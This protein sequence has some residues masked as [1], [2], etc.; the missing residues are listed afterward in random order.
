[1]ERV[2]SALDPH[3]QEVAM[4]KQHAVPLAALLVVAMAA[5]DERAVTDPENAP[6]PEQVV[7]LETNLPP[8]SAEP[9]MGRHEFTD[10]VAMQVRVKP[11][12]RSRAVVNMQDASNV[13]ALRIVVQ[14]GARFPWH[15]HPGLVVVTVTEGE[16]VYVYADDCVERPYPVGTAFIDPGDNVHYAF[17]PTGGETV[18]IATFFGVPADGPLTLP[19]DAAREAALNEQCGVSP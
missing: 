16:L 12:N 18:L 13:A 8:I 17:N 3:E 10:D 7:S 5:C 15:T 4:R 14:P 2:P 6:A 19:V 11:Q 9:L 1:M